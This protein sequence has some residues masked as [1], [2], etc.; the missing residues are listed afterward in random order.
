MLSSYQ[1]KRD[2]TKTPEPK[3]NNG[4]RKGRGLRFV[5]QKHDARR[6]H[7]DHRLEL[8]G[9][10]KSWAAPKGIPLEPG[11]KHLAVMVEDHPLDYADFE[12]EIPEGSYGAGEVIVWD[13]GLYAPEHG[14]DPAENRSAAE[15][16]IREGLEA[17]KLSIVLVGE[18]L[19]GSWALIHTKG[20]NWVL[21]KHKND[22][23]SVVSRANKASVV[24][25]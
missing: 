12:G 3:A 18:K 10:L 4:K 19:S 2:F 13:R 20:E 16:A 6:L 14:P 17:G 24:T 21:L 11:E 5:V 8:D 7:Y 1:K 22:E 15:R 9:V 25:G 23:A